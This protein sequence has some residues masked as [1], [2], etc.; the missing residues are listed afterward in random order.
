ME[1]K[2]A[3]RRTSKLAEL[4]ELDIEKP[5]VLAGIVVRTLSVTPQAARRIVGEL[6]FAR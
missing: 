4:I 6:R 2:L 1:R 3:R 5:V